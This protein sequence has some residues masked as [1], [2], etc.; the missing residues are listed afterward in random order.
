MK[1]TTEITNL[2]NKPKIISIC[3]D[4]NTGKSN[5]LYHTIETLRKEKSFKLYTPEQIYT[6]SIKVLY[7]M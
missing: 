3:G 4:V 2:F 1:K 5:L 7:I 6:K